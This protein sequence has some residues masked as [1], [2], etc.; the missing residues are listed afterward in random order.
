MKLLRDRIED[1]DQQEEVERIERPTEIGREQ[2]VTLR[3][4]QGFRSLTAELTIDI[5]L[6][7]HS[8]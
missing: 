4:V 3:G 1:E 2:S 5:V 7:S 8:T 6:A